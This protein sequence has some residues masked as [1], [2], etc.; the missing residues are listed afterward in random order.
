MV[1]IGLEVLLATYC[2]LH[3]PLGGTTGLATAYIAKRAL[4]S[5]ADHAPL[6]FLLGFLGFLAGDLVAV[7]SPPTGRQHILEGG[8]A[9]SGT[10]PLLAPYRLAFAFG[11]AILAVVLFR[12][13]LHRILR[14]K[15]LRTD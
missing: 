8:T 14:T 7:F 6:D 12:V 2:L 10:E 9:T 5:D 15:K 1:P 11:G 4:R 3:L 13:S